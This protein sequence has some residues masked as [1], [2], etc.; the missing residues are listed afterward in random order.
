MKPAIKKTIAIVILVIESV[1]F[2][3]LTPSANYGEWAVRVGCAIESVLSCLAYTVLI[4]FLNR[5]DRKTIFR[6]ILFSTIPYLQI[7]YCALTY[8]YGIFSDFL[9]PFFQIAVIYLVGVYEVKLRNR[10]I[11]MSSLLLSA[12]WAISLSGHLYYYNISSDAETV[13]VV[14]LEKI[15]AIIVILSVSVLTIAIPVS[16]KRE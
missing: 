7:I 2:L 15:I 4:I 5:H 6:D 14:T 9:L 3:F 11:V 10:V 13:G 16:P 12:L 1:L 8:K